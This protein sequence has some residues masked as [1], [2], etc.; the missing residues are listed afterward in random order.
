MAT[1]KVGFCTQRRVF[2]PFTYLE[3]CLKT[4]LYRKWLSVA[5]GWAGSSY[6]VI[7][8]FTSIV[9]G[10]CSNGLLKQMFVTH[11]S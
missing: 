9:M 7:E 6:S 1:R 10:I 4:V 2:Y 11:F 3:T 8:Y 5:S